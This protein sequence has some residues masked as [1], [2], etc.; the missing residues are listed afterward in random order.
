M[1]NTKTKKWK[2]RENPLPELRRLY[3]HCLHLLLDAVTRIYLV[4]FDS[5]G[6]VVLR[7]SSYNNKYILRGLTSS[8]LV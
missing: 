4:P 7:I 5:D 2:V 3:E 8:S 1:F 6:F